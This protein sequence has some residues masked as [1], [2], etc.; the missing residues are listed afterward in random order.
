MILALMPLGVEHDASG[1]LLAIRAV[2]IL[3]LMPLGVEHMLRTGIASPPI[4]D[5]RIDAVRR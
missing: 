4:C 2:V 1:I 5:P 3:A